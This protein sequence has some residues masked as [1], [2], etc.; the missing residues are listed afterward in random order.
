MAAYVPDSSVSRKQTSFVRSR[1]GIVT[2]ILALLLALFLIRPG[3]GRL[4]S[5]VVTAI[6]MALGRQG[7]VSSVHIRLLPHPGFDLQNFVGHDDPAFSARS[8]IPSQQGT[9]ELRTH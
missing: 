8:V 5:R 6:G 2:L 9:A 1:V 3:A 4:R 7:G